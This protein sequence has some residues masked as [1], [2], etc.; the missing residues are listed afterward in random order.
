[1]NLITSWTAAGSN[2]LMVRICYIGS[3]DPQYFSDCDYTVGECS[4]S[5]ILGNVIIINKSFCLYFPQKRLEKLL[6]KRYFGNFYNLEFLTFRYIFSRR[7]NGI[8]STS[9]GNPRWP[10]H[11]C[12]CLPA[13]AA[14]AYSLSRINRML[15]LCVIGHHSLN[16]ILYRWHH[17]SDAPQIPTPPSCKIVNL[18]VHFFKLAIFCFLTHW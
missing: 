6:K 5:K 16:S 12:H 9:R 8:K 15:L 3:G 14:G 17:R 2:S 18:S 10:S 4:M 11:H 1:M 13:H 7:D